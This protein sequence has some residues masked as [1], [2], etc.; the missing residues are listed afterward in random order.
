MKNGSN[1]E[2][3][4]QPMMILTID[5]GNGQ[6]DKL[7]LYDLNNIDK[8]TYD[9][10]VKNKLD[11]NTMQEINTQIQNVLKDK[12]FEEEQEIENVFQEIKEE[13]DEKITENNT[14]EN[15]I[16]DKERESIIMTNNSNEQEIQKDYKDNKDNKY[17]NDNIIANINEEN[18]NNDMNINSIDSALV[19]P[20]NNDNNMVKKENQSIRSNSIK[21]YNNG[22]K[23][24]TTMNESK[25]ENNR[26]NKSKN[27]KKKNIKTN[28]KEAFALAKEITA[29]S[30]KMSNKQFLE[31]NNNE[32]DMN[33]NPSIKNDL[34]DNNKDNDNNIEENKDIKENNKI[35]EN[36]NINIDDINKE[37]GKHFESG[38]INNININNDINNNLNHNSNEKY[39]NIIKSEE[40]SEKTIVNDNIK[41]VSSKKILNNNNGNTYNNSDINA[42][43]TNTNQTSTKKKIKTSSNNGSNVNNNNN[44]GKNLYERGMKYKENEKEKLKILKHNLEVDDEEDNTFIPKINKLSE[45][46]KEKIKEKK[47]ECYNPEIINNYKKYKQ[48]KFEQ[49]QKKKDEEFNKVY[50]FKPLINRSH[51]NSKVIKNRSNQKKDKNKDSNIINKIE[52]RFDKLYNYRIDYKENKDKLQQK[53]YNEYSFKPK[54]NENSSF[55]K[56]N[57]PFNERLQTYSNKTKENLVKIQKVYERE[58]GYNEPFKPQ[59]NN[60]KNKVLLKD[61]EGLFNNINNNNKDNNYIDPYTKLY[62]Y[63][64]KYE[65][66]KNYLAEKYY[67]EH[68]RPPQISETTQEIIN[69]KKEKCFKLIFR[70]LDSDED[71]Q[72]SS[73]HMNVSKLPKNVFKILEPIFNELKEENETL[74]EVEFVFVCEQLYLSLSW[75]EKRELTNFQDIIKRNEKKEKILKEKNNFSFEPKINKMN[76]RNYSYDKNI[77]IKK[78]KD[79]DNIDDINK[80]NDIIN[81]KN[82][83]GINYINYANYGVSK[84]NYNNINNSNSSNCYVKKRINNING[85]DKDNNK[86]KINNRINYF[87][88]KSSN[89]NSNSE[90]CKNNFMNGS[91]NSSKYSILKN[92]NFNIKAVNIDTNLENSQKNVEKKINYDDFINVKNKNS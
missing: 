16:R 92:I 55:Y 51:S 14:N 29:Q 34:N 26:S 75:N 85:N 69:K 8:E 12:Q 61:R 47:L 33:N 45:T 21:S 68:N 27:S 88:L 1:M 63:G 70:A 77:T 71:N 76:K 74:N 56:L 44:I 42:Q 82:A 41:K 19:S 58:Q 67:Q 24:N 73:N 13:E 49:L 91:N 18:M 53:I 17:N 9:F 59:I 11:F 7:Q 4:L 3:D 89:Y 22:G 83:N 5:I 48:E 30:Q 23:N 31:N 60:N 90:I 65:Q 39:S 62:L 36:N 66:E 80:I 15:E 20:G 79:K 54:I 87:N 43:K 32:N 28:I 38:E 10:C 57:K 2:T 86:N 35:I 78:E 72:I 84:N 37:N 81:Q 25:K 50:T 64:K 6:V 52:S 40:H 46:Q